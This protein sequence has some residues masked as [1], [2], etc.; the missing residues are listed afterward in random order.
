[1]TS[2]GE[3][4]IVSSMASS[5]N[6]RRASSP[7]TTLW[8]SKGLRAPAPPAG[9][10]LA[11]ALALCSAAALPSLAFAQAQAVPQTK[12]DPAQQAKSAEEPSAAEAAKRRDTIR[13]GIDSEILELVQKLGNEKEGAYNEELASLLGST[14]SPRLRSAI[15]DLF[16]SLE[17]KG[18][19]DQ[20]LKLVQDRDNAAAASV[21]AA[22]SYLAAIRSKKALE[23]APSILKEDNSRQDKKPILLALIRLMGRAGG[24]EEEGL[25][26]GWF[27]GDSATEDVRQEAIKALGE[28][29]STKAAERLAAIARDPEKDKST[30]MNACEALGKI[31]DPASV[32]ALIEAANGD[33]PNVQEKAVSALASFGIEASD[34]AL[35]EALRYSSV[36][37][38]MAACKGIATRKLDSAGPFLRY[39]AVN[40]PEKA[41]RTEAYRALAALGGDSFAFLREKMGD[42]K[43]ELQFRTL[44]FG[45]LMRKDAAGSMKELVAALT[46]EA[47]EK[48]KTKDSSL[49]VA[50]VREI[51][52]AFDAPD[53]APLASLLLADKDPLMRVGAIE[54]ARKSKAKGFRS[55]LERLAKD[56]PSEM[57]R[58]RA[59]DALAQLG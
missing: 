25:L 50:Y 47:V 6:S 58:K 16:S 14:K 20:A 59:T 41:V 21:S 5:P 33:D 15:F 19:E 40:D 4:A 42:K 27:E 30:R 31:K 29:G 54:W 51:A 26:L 7:S 28:I 23:L 49:Y 32:Q 2:S 10:L 17:W 37:S 8:P 3:Y 38:R 45:L 57:I 44:C 56:D 53:A 46:N 11:L 18:A 35:V 22:L 12:A 55:E 34:A 36:K 24:S 48:E 43:N 9:A 52:N 1:M 39:K 13:Y